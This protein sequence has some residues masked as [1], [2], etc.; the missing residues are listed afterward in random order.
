[1]GTWIVCT[2]RGAERVDYC[3]GNQH[4]L[5]AEAFHAADALTVGTFH[6]RCGPECG[7]WLPVQQAAK[8]TRT[9]PART[10]GPA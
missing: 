2:W 4:A 8:K 7:M 5:L 1:M 9:L 10:V 3:E 6:H